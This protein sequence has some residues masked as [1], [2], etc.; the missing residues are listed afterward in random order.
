MEDP[1]R[2]P[3]KNTRRLK[4]IEKKELLRRIW[5]ALLKYLIRD[6][7][8]DDYTQPIVV[9]IFNTLRISPRIYGVILGIISYFRYYAYIA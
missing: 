8:F 9:K 6:P 3:Q 5:N 2:S 1:V 4:Q 7:I